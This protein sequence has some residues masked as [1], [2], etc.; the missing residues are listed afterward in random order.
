MRGLIV[1]SQSGFYTVSTD[2]GS[3]VCRLRGKLKHG[4]RQGDIIAVGDWVK[5]TPLDSNNGVI[6]AIEPRQ[7]LFSRLAP[8]PQG[9]YQQVLIANPDQIV[10]VFACSHPAPRFGMLDRFLVIAEKQ[11]LP[12]IIVANKIDLVSPEKAIELFARYQSIGYPVVFT[13]CTHQSG[14]NE[15]HTTLTNKISLL[16]GPSGAGKSSLLN[17]IQAG[18]GLAVRK[19][20][21]VTRKGRHTTVVRELFPLEN[22]GYVADTPGLK[23][24]AFWDIEAE[25][26][27]AYFP[28]MRERVADCAFSNCTH[29]QEPGCAV[30]AAVAE[31][32]IHPARHR[33]YLRMRFGG[34]EDLEKADD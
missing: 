18:L 3:Y 16:S 7:H 15:L 17:A 5:I 29:R 22:G 26:L 31:G 27:D 4:P 33:S 8:N 1:R 11:G 30:L 2:Q 12:A 32:Q 23:A 28:E 9:L 13:S 6:E 25:E 21:T 20:S 24:L 10:L 34:E 19:V 14:I